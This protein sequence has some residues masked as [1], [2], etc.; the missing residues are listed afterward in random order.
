MAARD[1]VTYPD[2][3]LRQQA[4]A[5]T[6]VDTN[7]KKLIHDM[8]DTMHEANGVG[9]AANQIGVLQKVIVFDD[10][11]GPKVLINPKIVHAS[12]E[13]VGIEGC[14]SVPGLQGEVRRANEIEVKGLDERGKPVKIKAEGLTARIIQHELDHL[15]GVLFIDR[16]EPNSLHYVTATEEEEAIEA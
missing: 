15:N 8:I 16:A 10:G 9:F 2:P 12:G 11:T 6:K 14:L 3:V 4:K 1:V 13:Q 7:T 5:V